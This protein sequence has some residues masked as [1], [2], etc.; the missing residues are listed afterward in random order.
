MYLNF[1]ILYVETY[2]VANKKANNFGPLKQSSAQRRMIKNSQFL[3][4]FCDYYA[5]CIMASKANYKY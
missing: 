3:C 2:E 4:H 1:Q 5:N